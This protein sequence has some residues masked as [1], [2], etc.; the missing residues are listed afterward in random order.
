M[1]FAVTGDGSYDDQ[2]VVHR[3]MSRYVSPPDCSTLVIEGGATGAD[4][5]VRNWC[6][7]NGI[8]CATI[9][10]LWKSY[11]R[12][13]GPTRNGVIL[14]LRPKFVL[15]FPGGKGTEDMCRQAEAAGIEVRRVQ[16]A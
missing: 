1:I 9:P 11:G 2:N 4:F 16:D 6:K 13:S 7:R 8:H 5:L 12:A 14:M 3:E 10:A 15:A